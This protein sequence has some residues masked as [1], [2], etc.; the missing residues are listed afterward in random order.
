MGPNDRGWRFE[1]APH[2]FLLR[3]DSSGQCIG[4]LA[5]HAIKGCQAVHTGGVSGSAWVS[6]EHIFKM[7]I[8]ELG[9]WCRQYHGRNLG[10]ISMTGQCV[11]GIWFIPISD[12]S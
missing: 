11:V 7:H 6:E 2:N 5:W 4:T 8:L 12:N 9:L 1:K 10:T 3:V